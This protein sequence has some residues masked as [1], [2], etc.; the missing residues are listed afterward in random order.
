MFLVNVCKTFLSQSAGKMSGEKHP[1][2]VTKTRN[3]DG[4]WGMGNGKLKWE[5]ENGKLNIFYTLT[6]YNVK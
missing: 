5:I 1:A 3:G 2:D 6:F 4:E